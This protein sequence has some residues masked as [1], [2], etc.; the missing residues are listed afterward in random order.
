MKIKVFDVVE[1]RNNKLAT[2]L[3]IKDNQYLTEIVDRNGKTLEN[4][5]INQ[6]EIKQII[7]TK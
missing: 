2:I 5:Y 4:R 7:Y 6:E 1:L 3:E